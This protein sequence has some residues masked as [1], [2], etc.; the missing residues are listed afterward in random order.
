MFWL[1]LNF[2]LKLTNA[3][4]AQGTSARTQI[5]YSKDRNTNQFLV[6]SG[7]SRFCFKD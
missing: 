4:N 7:H 6:Y 3:K 1:W 5:Y 2:P